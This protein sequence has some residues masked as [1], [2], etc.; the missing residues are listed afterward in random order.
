MHATI[1]Q[2]LTIRDREPVTALIKQ[3][4]DNCP[5]CRN[6]LDE[7]A[8]TRDEL[9]RIPMQEPV[10][11]YWLEINS[12]AEHRVRI[13]RRRRKLLFYSG[14]GLA[15]TVLLTTIIFISQVP[16]EGKHFN[17]SPD[18]GLAM[19]NGI[20]SNVGT[21]TDV[22]SKGGNQRISD[23]SGTGPELD[24]LIARSAQLEAALHALPQRPRVTRAGTTDLITGLQDGVAL[25]D[26]QLNFKAADMSPSVSRTLWQQR[27]D[28]MNSLVTVRFAE[29]Q[30]RAYLPN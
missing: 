30:F 17:S 6:R 15:A 7:L 14:F 2:L 18:T 8:L 20:I 16:G 24:A 22:D 23:S 1:E 27:V 9:N 19:K 11:D 28:L 29:S 26:Y 13:S 5:L 3:H 10:Q 25:I 21:V 4:V 12:Q